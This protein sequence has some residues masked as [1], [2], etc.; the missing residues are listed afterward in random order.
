VKKGTKLDAKQRKSVYMAVSLSR[1][2][3]FPAFKASKANDKNLKCSSAKDTKPKAK[4]K[5]DNPAEAKKTVTVCYEMVT[6]YKNTRNGKLKGKKS[7]SELEAVIGSMWGQ[8]LDRWSQEMRVLLLAWEVAIDVLTKWVTKGAVSA[9]GIVHLEAALKK[10]DSAFGK[11]MT[12]AC[13][14][15]GGPV[16]VALKGNDDAPVYR[17]ATTR[18]H[19]SPFKRQTTAVVTFKTGSEWL[20]GILDNAR[21]VAEK[22][23]QAV[24]EASKAAR[25]AA[26]QVMSKGNH[27]HRRKSSASSSSNRSSSSSKS[28][29][30]SP[31]HPRHESNIRNGRR[32]D[33]M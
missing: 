8:F 32:D 1:A 12:H 5:D 27:R 29:S 22:V 33:N 11:L 10:L 31:A 24:K 25:L 19:A 26:K 14:D 28:R 4:Q 16:L 2:L 18:G 3:T 23:E 9:S 17:A 7:P 15:V 6:A 20:L 13:S 21:Q 30:R